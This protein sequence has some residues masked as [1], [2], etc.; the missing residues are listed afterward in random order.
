MRMASE[1]VHTATP[2]I[3]VTD[4][5]GLSVRSVAC[6][7]SAVGEEAELL[8]GRQN[9][10]LAGR[11]MSSQDPRLG[12]LGGDAVFNTVAIYSLG[13]LPLCV[14][15]VDSGSHIA[16]F[17]DNAER[18]NSWDGRATE[19]GIELD[20]LGRPVVLHEQQA[21]GLRKAVERYGYAAMSSEAARHNRCGRLIR[22]D[23]P[24]GSL[25]IED[26]GLGGNTLKETRTFLPDMNAPNWPAS[27]GERDAMLVPQNYTTHSLYAPTG[28]LIEQMDARGNRRSLFFDRAGQ[29][30]DLKL[31]PAGDAEQTLVSAREYDAAGRMLGQRLGNDVAEQ[32]QFDPRDGHVLR[33][34]ASRAA[35][36]SLYDHCYVTDPVGNVLSI[37]DRSQ[38]VSHF[39]NQRIEPVQTRTYDSLYRLIQASGYEMQV[40][41][42]GPDLPTL[43]TELADGAQWRNY[44]QHYQYD[45]A[46]NMLMLRHEAQ[47]GNFTRRMQVMAHSNRAMPL[48]EDAEPPDLE[49]GFDANGN[50]LFLQP[51][52][53]LIW[54]ARNRLTDA[55]GQR[56]A[57]GAAG[58]RLRKRSA[59]ST[60]TLTHHHDVLYLPGLELHDKTATGEQYCVLIAEDQHLAARCLHWD[61]GLPEG[62]FNDALRYGLGDHLRSVYLEVDRDADLISEE[63][64]YP[65]GG[66]AWWAARSAVEADYKTVRYSGRERDDSGLYYYGARYYAPWL[67]RWISPDPAGAVDG[68]NLYAFARNNPTTL[69]DDGGLQ[70]VWSRARTC[71]GVPIQVNTDRADYSESAQIRVR[72]SDL[73][74]LPGHSS[75][76]FATKLEPRKLNVPAVLYRAEVD[77]EDADYTILHTQF[78]IPESCIQ[79]TEYIITYL[80]GDIRPFPYSPEARDSPGMPL[81]VP[82]VE[83]VGWGRPVNISDSYEVDETFKTLNA[84]GLTERT[85]PVT[86]GQGLVFANSA[87]SNQLIPEN[88]IHFMAVTAVV[89]NDRNETAWAVM[90]DLVEPA[91]TEDNER[92][93]AVGNWAPTLVKSITEAR[94]NPLMGNL[95]KESFSVGIVQAM[96]NEASSSVRTPRADAGPV[97]NAARLAGRRGNRALFN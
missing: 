72:T 92:L 74:M 39:R 17:N 9:Y 95:S 80:A 38:A 44:T 66:T 68:L 79:S 46:D 87:N 25:E 36:P 85:L 58:V 65:F 96:S 52:Q 41:S 73:N 62:V 20:V 26:Y 40:P 18:I 71:F 42:L 55:N 23:D 57:Y 53:R 1:S 81:R 54:D 56:N 34:F 21:G 7:R 30:A 32:Y 33:Q 31:Q 14:S 89:L 47:S 15:S 82:N 3:F 60:G 48:F 19:W 22:H 43:A 2:E 70:A 12:A 27:L 24:A 86:L 97:G 11:P 63:L 88:S 13:G 5:R 28:E 67:Q 8:I 90:S 94:K 83:A 29:A 45:A 61:E 77:S 35:G 76:G 10:D 16:L 64:Y 49:N 4:G 51:G 84:A 75:S 50:L 69:I 78:A 59:W 6:L 37:T 91:R 93:R